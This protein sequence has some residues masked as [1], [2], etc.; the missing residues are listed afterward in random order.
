MQRARGSVHRS[1][2][3]TVM[4]GAEPIR[5]VYCEQNT[6]GT[7]GGSYYSLL[8]LVEGLNPTRYRPT[9]VFYTEHRLLSAFREAGIETLVWAKPLPFSFASSLPRWLRGVGAPLLVLQKGLNLFRTFLVPALVKA[10]YLRAQRVALVHLNNSISRNH[11]W[12]LAAR[13]AGCRCVTHE[14]GINDS[15]PFLARYLGRRL[16]A[17]ICISEAVRQNLRERG[18]D[19]ANLITIFNGLDPTMM[20]LRVP[21]SELRRLHGI[22]PEAPIVVMIGNIKGWKGQDTLIRAIDSVRQTVSDVCCIL[23]GA[24]SS[25]DAAYEQ[26]LRALSA[27]LG[28]EQRVIFA[29]SHD[30]V[31]D[32]LI[33]ASVVVHASVLPE[34]FGRVLLEA[35]ACR[36]AVVAANAG[37]VPEIVKDGETGLLFPPGDS[38]R[39][40]TALLTLLTDPVEARRL[41]ENGYTRLMSRF[42]VMHN[43]EATEK[44]YES[45][46]REHH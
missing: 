33:L 28:L 20:R 29:G 17:V 31:A 21:A 46:L 34:P 30:A 5:V 11:D 3:P 35:M 22:P 19:F 39:L 44:L 32:Y 25:A 12:M 24:T 7:V 10:R 4:T 8:Y 43:V 37:G 45:I 1:A 16:D 42:R 9:V 6:D 36:R 14:R 15:Y 26:H 38:G 27:S 23:V 41:G 18:A 13:I 2:P 40:S